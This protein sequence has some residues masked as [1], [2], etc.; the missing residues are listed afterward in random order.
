MWD[1]LLTAAGKLLGSENKSGE[2]Q[3]LELFKGQE[4]KERDFKLELNKIY[5]QKLER[6]LKDRMDARGMQ[7]AALNQSDVF[8]KRFIYYLSGFILFITSVLALFPMFF[9]IP[10]GNEAAVTRATDFFYVLAGG[11]VIGFFY[12][13]NNSN[14]N[15][16]NPE[17][18]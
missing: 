2:S 17:A 11:S 6:E 3:I 1:I 7:V 18:V 9:E 5:N 8:S 13:S 4:Q 14:D 15:K 10:V 12:G 16:K